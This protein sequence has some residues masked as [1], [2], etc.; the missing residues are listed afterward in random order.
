MPEDTENRISAVLAS[1]DKGCDKSI[2]REANF[3]H[4]G[5]LDSIDFLELISAC[6]RVFDVTIDLLEV[7]VEEISSVT[8]LAKFID[9]RKKD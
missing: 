8:G 7:E 2:D 1:L 6:E 3:F 9:S 4:D 5:L